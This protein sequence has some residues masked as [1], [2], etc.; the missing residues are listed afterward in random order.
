MPM[1]ITIASGKGGVGKSSLSTNLALRLH[2]AFGRTLLFDSDLLM[3]NSHILLDFQPK[4]D[5]IDVLEF[6]CTLGEAIA[7][8]DGGLSVLAGRTG[9]SVGINKVETDLQN[10]IFKLRSLKDVFEYI[11][12]DA[13]AGIG[14][15]L[16]NTLA[17][18]DRVL[19]VLLG[20]ATSFV[21]A[22]ALIKNSYVERGISE[23]SVLVNMVNSEL[24]AKAIFESFNRT[25]QAFL[26]VNLTYT[27]HVEVLQEIH[28][29]SIKFVP[30]ARM[31]GKHKQ[32]ANFDA[33]LDQILRAP[34]NAPRLEQKIP[35][36]Q[37]G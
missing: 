16:M 28:A 22:Y 5:V 6:R 1:I 19:I 30:M 15:D 8:V 11:V 32:I 29:S 33:I 2:H 27:G 18:S 26:P 20:Q 10:L 4:R 21:D 17:K 9:A 37:L 23:Y 12:V 34:Q 25:V 3:A 36:G 35:I 31:D 13:P 14:Q 24:Q 7:V